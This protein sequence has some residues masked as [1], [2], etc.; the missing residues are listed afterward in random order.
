M[1]K[2]ENKLTTDINLRGHVYYMTKFD[3]TF[4]QL[5][6]KI[7]ILQALNVIGYLKPSPIQLKC[8]PYLLEGYDVLGI[9]QT[10]SGKTAA[11]VLPILNN[12]NIDIK[13]PQALIV[14][15]TRELALQVAESCNSF[16]RYMHEVNILAIYGGQRYDLQLRGLHKGPHIIVGTPGRLLDHLERRT[17]H[18]SQLRTF[19]LDEADEMLRMG[20]IEDVEN[21]MA[22]IPKGQQT[23]LFSATM[24][25]EICRISRNFM[26]NPQEIRIHT[27]V[28]TRPDIK[29]S[30]WLI[31]G[32][33]KNALVRFLEVEEF[34]AAIIF[35]RTKNATL[36]IAEFLENSGYKCAALNGDMNQNL[37]EQTLERFKKGSI[38]ILIATDVAA[39]GLDVDRISIVINYDMPMDTDSYI[40]RIG[41]TGRAGRKG[42]ALLFIN[43]REF[44]FL[45]NL[46]R[47]MKMTIQKVEL[48]TTE[49]IS[50]CRITKFVA[51]IKKHLEDSDIASY[52]KIFSLLEEEEK[53]DNKKLS[54]TLLKLA[55]GDRPLIL[56]SDKK[57]KNSYNQEL[58]YQVNKNLN[59][60][61][62]KS[63]IIYQESTNNQIKMD[64]YRIDVGRDDSIDIRHIVGAIANEGNI[65]SRYIGHIKLFNFY[66][67][68]ELPKN[69]PL[70]LLNHFSKIRIFNKP[71]NMQLLGDSI[72]L[73]K[74]EQHFIAQKKNNNKQ[75]KVEKINLY[76]RI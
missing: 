47:I 68:I 26:K 34:D 1:F 52:A 72:F 59:Y 74:N 13:S 7:P 19:I 22:Q 36:E 45:R 6:L 67:T 58:Q 32:N 12:I 28:T 3:K 25:N 66:S 18:L 29:Q 61:L 43:H 71:L 46:E 5:G 63:K 8:I 35:V 40:H 31:S 48:P 51:K 50:K 27:N 42:S 38:D 53:I 37:R 14:T 9:A 24:P 70:E 64:L 49:A 17:L 41:R 30:Y 76:R 16:A 2:I 69:M 4:S 75:K 33:K 73:K 60:H 23:V 56:S 44:R 55:Q 10:G 15:P 20:F 39:R 62:K 21:I 65:N 57:N 54:A 11:F